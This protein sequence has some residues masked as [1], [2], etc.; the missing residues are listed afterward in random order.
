MPCSVNTGVR[1]VLNPHNADPDNCYEIEL[2]KTGV[3]RRHGSRH[4]FYR[5]LNGNRLLCT[6]TVPARG[7]V[8]VSTNTTQYLLYESSSWTSVRILVRHG[9]AQAG[10]IYERGFSLGR[11]LF[12]DL[13]ESIPLATQ[14]FMVFLVGVHA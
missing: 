12:V 1:L 5:L 4:R 3:D 2:G 7:V 13:D 14:C 10:A 6:A 11:R 8:E 9:G